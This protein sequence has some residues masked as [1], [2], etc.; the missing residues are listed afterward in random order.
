MADLEEDATDGQQADYLAAELSGDHGAWNIAI[1]EYHCPKCNLWI[2]IQQ[3][4]LPDYK[5]LILGGIKKPPKKTI[6]FRG[7]FS[8][9]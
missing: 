7:L 3:E 8:S 6:I 1:V 5:E 9:T 2:Q 4:V